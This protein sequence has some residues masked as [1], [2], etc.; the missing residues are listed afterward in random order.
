MKQVVIKERKAIDS[1]KPLVE[2]VDV[3][4]NIKIKLLLITLI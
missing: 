1:T 3:T 2:V 4:K